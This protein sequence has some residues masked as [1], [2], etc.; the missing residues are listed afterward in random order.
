MSDYRLYSDH[1]ELV[2][3]CLRCLS[4]DKNASDV[5]FTRFWLERAELFLKTGGT[6]EQRRQVE[7]H[8]VLHLEAIASAVT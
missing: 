5:A 8:R 1:S 3:A 7:R 4:R 6:E 2:A